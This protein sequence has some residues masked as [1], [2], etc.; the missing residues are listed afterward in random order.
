VPQ[1]IHAHL[2]PFPPPPQHHTSP[3]CFT[4]PPTTLHTRTR[5]CAHTLPRCHHTSP[6]LHAHTHHARA[7]R[8]VPFLHGQAAPADS[9]LH[10]ALPT[11]P[12]SFRQAGFS[13]HVTCCVGHWTDSVG[14]LGCGL[15]SLLS[16]RCTACHCLHA[17]PHPLAS[18][19]LPASPTPAGIPAT[20]SHALRL[21]QH[22]AAPPHLPSTCSFLINQAG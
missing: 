16:P 3:A 19:H 22:A 20:W 18:C 7:P 5:D 2:G 11:H 14:N 4:A 15:P 17:A 9:A 13:P 8:I 12:L 10:A 6:Y 1:Y 21:L